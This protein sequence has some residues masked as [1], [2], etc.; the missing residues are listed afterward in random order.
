VT[1]QQNKNAVSFSELAKDAKIRFSDLQYFGYANKLGSKDFIK[2]DTTV[3]ANVKW[4]SGLND[5]IVNQREADLTKW[6]KERL[7]KNNIEIKRE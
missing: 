1:L 5:S 2:V 4:K 7:K 3:V 6:L